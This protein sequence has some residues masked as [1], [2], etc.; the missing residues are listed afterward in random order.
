MNL[1]FSNWLEI[2]SLS[3]SLSLSLK[4]WQLPAVAKSKISLSL[5]FVF[6]DVCNMHH[7][8]SAIILSFLVHFLTLFVNVS[9]FYITLVIFVAIMLLQKVRSFL[10][11]YHVIKFP[12]YLY[13]CTVVLL[14]NTVHRLFAF[15]PF[16]RAM[17]I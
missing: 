5:S 3:L 7:T 16:Q 1:S 14:G 8:P 9:T 6:K 11:L 13:C 12:V 17:L 15:F 2:L 10:A 4:H